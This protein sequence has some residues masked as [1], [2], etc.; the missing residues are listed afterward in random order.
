MKS[1]TCKLIAVFV[2]IVVFFKRIRQLLGAVARGERESTDIV[3]QS[4]VPRG[5][6]IR[7]GELRLAAV[8]IPLLAQRM[9]SDQFLRPRRVREQDDVIPLP[10]GREK[11]VDA[12]GLQELLGHDAAEQRLAV[13]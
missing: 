3:D 4:A 5:D 1:S 11:P 2:L 10:I 8:I 9:E 13:S 7:Q 6:K 12:S